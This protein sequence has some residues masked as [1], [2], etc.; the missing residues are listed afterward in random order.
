MEIIIGRNGDQPTPITNKYVSRK[1]ARVTSNPDGSYT[2]ENISSTG[3]T[4]VD[5]R[6]VVKTRITADTEIQLG[7]EFRT[8]LR[9]L[10]AKQPAQKPQVAQGPTQQK[11]V[12]QQAQ[13]QAPVSIVHLSQVYEQ[14]E[15]NKLE[16]QR[17]NMRKANKKNFLRM[18]PSFV[19]T[20]ISI[21]VIVMGSGPIMDVVKPFMGVM[22]LGALAFSAFKWQKPDFTVL[23][24]TQSNE[25]EFALRWVCPKCGNPLPRLPYEGLVNKGSCNAC[26]TKWIG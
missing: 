26:R 25:R 8:T 18:V 9:A 12:Q 1:H 7:S 13:E 4:Y 16:I 20:L 23:E 3:Q 2:I 22:S 21:L 14:Y 11:N 10:L 15:A 5:G 6:E 24:E 17:E 19:L